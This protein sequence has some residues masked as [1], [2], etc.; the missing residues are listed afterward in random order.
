MA[1]TATPAH[2][3]RRCEREVRKAE[4]HYRDAVRRHG[5]HS[6]QAEHARREVENARARCR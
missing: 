5:E 4:E 1:A 3:E 6:K 2:A